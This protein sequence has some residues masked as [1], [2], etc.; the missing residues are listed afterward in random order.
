MFQE[1]LL[2]LLISTVVLLYIMKL[3][4][5]FAEPIQ[6][7]QFLVS[8]VRQMTHLP[9]LFGFLLANTH[10]NKFLEIIIVWSKND[11]SLRILHTSICSGVW[12][13]AILEKFNTFGSKFYNLSLLKKSGHTFNADSFSL[14]RTCK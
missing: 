12:T 8:F 11:S 13:F 1:P 14:Q 4:Q 5:E 3:F 6:D 9:L 2:L 10:V 7:K